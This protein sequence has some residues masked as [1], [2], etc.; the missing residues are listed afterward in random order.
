MAKPEPDMNVWLAEAKRSEN[1]EMIGADIRPHAIAALERLV[2]HIKTNL[3]Q[4][5][6]L[7][8]I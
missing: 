2:G 5:K 7:F 4:E 1:A 3:V 8:A 6:E